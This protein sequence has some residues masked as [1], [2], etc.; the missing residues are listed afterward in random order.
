MKMSDLPIG[1]PEE[2]EQEPYFGTITLKIIVTFLCGFL[3][4]A[5]VIA[6]YAVAIVLKLN[7]L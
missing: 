7:I 5:F 6:G 4:F 3:G 1:P 2:L